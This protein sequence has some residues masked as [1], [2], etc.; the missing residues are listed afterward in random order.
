MEN[1]T[2][3]GTFLCFLEKGICQR[4]CRQ[5]LLPTVD[6]VRAGSYARHALQK[7]SSTPSRPAERSHAR[8]ILTDIQFWAPFLV[9]LAG[10]ALLVVLH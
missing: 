3:P 5:P 8:A 4:P 2:L 10:L 6:T 1:C 9:L 7:T